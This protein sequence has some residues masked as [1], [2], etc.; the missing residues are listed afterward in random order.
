MQPGEEGKAAGANNAIRELGGVFGVA[1]LAAIF[2]ANGSYVSPSE[3][4]GGLI[5][6]MAVGAVVV[7]SGA[8]AALALPG[9]NAL[10]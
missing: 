6:A 8:I 2:S 4:V 9:P 7:G 3:Y 5:P 10:D 1:V